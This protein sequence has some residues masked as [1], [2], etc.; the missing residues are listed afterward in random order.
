MDNECVNLIKT[1]GFFD[2]VIGI[3]FSL[4]LSGPFGMISWFFL[5]GI[6]CGFVNIV[7]NSYTIEMQLMKETSFKGLLTVIAYIF[8]I[9]IVC[10]TSLVIITKSEVSFFIFIAGYTAQILAVL[11]Y[12]DSLRKRER[13]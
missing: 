1:I 11:C 10:G 7:I 4:I 3:I 9:A 13:V 12:G 2:L 6:M 8:K 5:L